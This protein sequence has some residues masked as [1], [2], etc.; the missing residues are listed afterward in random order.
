MKT[1]HLIYI[2][3]PLFL[4]G[5]SSSEHLTFN[6]VPIDGQLHRFAEELAKSEFNI[7]DSTAN[8]EIVLHGEFFNKNCKISVLGI[9]DNNIAYKV[10]VSL[11]KEG[12]DSLQTDFEKL[13][14]LFSLK[15]GM[16]TSKYQQYQKRERLVYKVPAKNIKEGDYTKYS[17]DSGEVTIEVQDGFL[18][19]TYLDHSNLELYTKEKS[20]SN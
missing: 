11:P 19:I 15:Y 1:K 14:K 4:N 17:T 2:L 16:G 10:I 13:Q 20:I 8:N 18:S 9:S 6:N 5:C 3:I 7:V 12:H